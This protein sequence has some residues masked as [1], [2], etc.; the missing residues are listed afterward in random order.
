MKER[1]P[2]RWAE[3]V[4]L[5]RTKEK[6]LKGDSEPFKTTRMFDASYGRKL[7]GIE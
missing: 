3:D 6:A 2:L 7:Q 4:L 5:A 1:G